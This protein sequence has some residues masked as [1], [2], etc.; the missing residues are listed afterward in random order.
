MPLRYIFMKKYPNYLLY[1]FIGLSVLLSACSYKKSNLKFSDSL[2]D[3]LSEQIEN[4]ILQGISEYGETNKLPRSF[5]GTET[6][7]TEP[8]AWTS[9]FYPGILWLTYE[10]T[11]NP[12]IKEQAEQFTALL[13]NEQFNNEDHDTGFKMYCSYGN[14]LRLAPKNEYNNILVQ[15]ART[16]TSR[17]NPVVGCIRSWDHHQEKWQYP[18]IIDNLMN[19]ELLMW[20]FK[21]TQDSLFYTI[22]INHADKTLENHFRQDYSSYHVIDYDTITGKVLKR[23][24]YQGYS[25][26]SAWARGQ[27]WALYGYTM[28]Y[29]ETQLEKYLQMAENVASFIIN[30]KNLPADKIPYW[31]F[32]A[33]NIPDAPRDASSA[34]IIASALYEL[35]GYSKNKDQFIDVADDMVKSLSS[36]AYFTPKEKSHSFLLDHSTGSFP[37]NM[38]INCPIIYADYYLLEA[39]LRKTKLKAGN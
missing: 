18:V 35:S 13:V 28:M 38:E 14:A 2:N 34:A 30:N 11:K 33:P 6:I 10:I 22:A 5:D 8:Q 31:D 39:L 24:T 36:D 20:A 32:N 21:Y 16:L 9:G 25:D 15:S 17:Y 37:R 4:R 23:N 29:R 1:I 26:E 7:M 19:L 3:T 12:T 27:A